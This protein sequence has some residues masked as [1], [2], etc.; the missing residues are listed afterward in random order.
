[1]INSAIQVS[2]LGKIKCIIYY[3]AVLVIFFFACNHCYVWL[4]AIERP[5]LETQRSRKRLFSTERFSNSL[6]FLNIQS[7]I[8]FI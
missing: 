7:K 2:T 4:D 5:G 3:F 6:N 8:V 1:M